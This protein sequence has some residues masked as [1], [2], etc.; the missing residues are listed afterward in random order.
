MAEQRKIR[1]AVIFGGRSPEH[2]ISCVTAGGVI[3]AIDTDRYEIV[4]VGIARDG[5]WVLYSADPAQL[6]IVDGRL[7]EVDASGSE[8]S[9]P[10]D[11]GGDLLVD[12]GD[13]P[14]RLGGIDVALPLLHGP[15]GEDGTVQ[16]LFE[17]MGI[18]YVGAGVFASAASMDKVFTKTLFTGHGIPTGSYVAVPDRAWRT[19]RKRVLDDIAELD[20]TVFVKPARGGSSVGI[21]KVGEAA[22]P[23]A[24]TAAVEEARRH[25]TK[26]IVEAAVSGREVECGVLESPDGGAP[27]VSQPAEIHVADGYDFY[28]FEAKYLSS[29]SLTIPAALPAEVVAEIRREAARTFEALGC[30]GLAR[31]DFF[32]ADDGRVYVNEINTMPGFTPSSAFPQMWAE[33]GL[34]YPSLVDR[35]IRAALDRGP[36]AG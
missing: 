19:E 15:L 11:G 8:V 14:R 16:G 18:P 5:S 31:V 28:D 29:S 23:E 10:F 12:D 30:A 24:V 13:G 6:A 32:Y 7:P 35:M 3:S 4:P 17:M 2:E 34:D 33:A 27:D 1:V 26:V 22:D 25:D 9:V 36:Q 21:S 20:G